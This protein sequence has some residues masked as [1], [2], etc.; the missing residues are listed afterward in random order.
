[1]R[2]PRTKDI[3]VRKQYLIGLIKL[4]KKSITS[5][6]LLGHILQRKRLKILCG[7]LKTMLKT[8]FQKKIKESLL[9]G[10]DLV[11]QRVLTTLCG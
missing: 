8:I 9:M 1:M 3:V 10:V 7:F 6:S 4:S 2:C 11:I 5:N